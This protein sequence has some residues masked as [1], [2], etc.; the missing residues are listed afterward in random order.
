MRGDWWTHVELKHYEILSQQFLP[1]CSR[2]VGVKKNVFIL[3]LFTFILFF[4]L[5]SSLPESWS[6]FTDDNILRSQSERTTSHKL[7]DEIEILMNTTSSEMWNQFNSVNVAFANRTSEAADAK[8]SLQTHLAKVVASLHHHL[9]KWVKKVEHETTAW[10]M[11]CRGIL[12]LFE[13]GCV[14]VYCKPFLSKE[15]TGNRCFFH[16]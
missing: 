8:N 2:T 9:Q 12:I 13:V 10:F 3:N 15:R 11:T 7:R 4:S 14:F 6:K 5:R 16:Y 1:V